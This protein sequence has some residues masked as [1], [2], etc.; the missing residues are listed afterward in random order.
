MVLSTEQKI[1]QFLD[2]FQKKQIQISE[3][4]KT[5]AEIKKKEIIETSKSNLSLVIETKNNIENIRKEPLNLAFLL[6]D[7]EI[8]NFKENQTNFD[9]I[10]LKS[11]KIKKNCQDNKIKQ[12]FS[13]ALEN[14]KVDK[15]N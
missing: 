9:E 13:N 11:M 10:P 2:D 15:L 4:M 6:K 8:S 5:P 14:P 3:Y 1:E 12:P 7:L